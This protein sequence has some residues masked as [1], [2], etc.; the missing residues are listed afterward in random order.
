MDSVYENKKNKLLKAA[1]GK[2]DFERSST[3]VLPTS[4]LK[5]D[6]SLEIQTG[7]IYSAAAVMWEQPESHHEALNCSQ[8]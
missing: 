2:A 1:E 4:A 6:F 7:W 5:P 3:C 8:K